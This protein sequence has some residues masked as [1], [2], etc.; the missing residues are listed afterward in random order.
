[1]WADEGDKRRAA[2]CG[3]RSNKIMAALRK[4]GKPGNR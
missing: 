3:A 1:M 2:A 4:T